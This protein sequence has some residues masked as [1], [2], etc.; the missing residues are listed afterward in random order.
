MLIIH[1][2]GSYCLFSKRT[3]NMKCHIVC[4][5]EDNFPS[6][7][8]EDPIW[9]MCPAKGVLFLAASYDIQARKWSKSST[10]VGLT[11]EIITD[12]THA[13]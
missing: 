13:E 5:K 7:S 6:G 12:N 1:K 2:S 4:E 11:E 10:D 9:N 8:P 3:S